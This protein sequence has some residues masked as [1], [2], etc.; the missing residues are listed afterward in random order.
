[1][2]SSPEP[3][4][5]WR[6]N[7]QTLD[8]SN[9]KRI[10]IVD[11][12]NL[13]IQD[14]RISDDGRYQ[15]VAKNV[16]GVR[17][18]VVAFLKVHVRPFLIRGPQNQTVV[19]GTSVVFQCRVG[20]EPL[21]DVLW[22][23]T[24]SG[25]NMPLDRVRIL[26]DRSLRIDDISAEDAGEYSCEADNAVGSIMASG[27]LVVHSPPT[28]TLRPKN[29]IGELTK[30]VLFECQAKGYP[31]PT[32]FWSIEGNRTLLF[33][34]A[35]YDNIETTET[36]DGGSILSITNIDR[37]DN[38][39]VIVCSA[40]N[41]VGSVSTRVVLSLNLQD[42]KPPPIIMQ[43]PA[44]QTLPIKSVA[45]LPCR[46]VGIPT[47]IISW[48]RDGIPVL[49]SSKVNISEFGMMTISDLN[50]NEDSGLY[51]CVASSKT[52][53][54]T[55]SAYLKLD[56]PTNPNIKFYRAPEASTFPGPPGKPQISENEDNSVTVS[57]VRS[58]KVGA[59]SI[60]GYQVE[61]FGRN[62]TEGWITV[63]SKIRDTSYTVTGLTTGIT[64]YFLVRSENSHGISTP[65]PLSEPIMV[66]MVRIYTN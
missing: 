58:N 22:R 60:L 7:G 56:A 53:K 16:V 2:N 51:T 1:M 5:F 41:G 63:A 15:C 25:G 62:A 59:S 24:A 42:D 66:G 18:S 28:F 14:A 35:K 31:K 61:M 20:G 27:T 26:E 55:W 21:P 17:E 9:S 10:R 37:S 11:G 45:T 33:P 39:K 36:A 54:S 49:P 3:T 34:G 30:E 19:T 52:G 38:G 44:N 23:R 32:L 8:L 64:Y 65:S 47:P 48:Y 4:V 6:K 40:V 50:K 57:W 46:A 12:G 13:A 43:G 29:Q